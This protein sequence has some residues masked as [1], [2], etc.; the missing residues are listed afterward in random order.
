MHWMCVVCNT[1]FVVSTKCLTH[2][3]NY[4]W[5][6]VGALGMFGADIVVQ[7]TCLMPLRLADQENNIWVSLGSINRPCGQLWLSSWHLIHTFC[8]LRNT[9]HSLAYLDRHLGEIGE[10]LM[11]GI[12][13]LSIGGSWETWACYTFITL[14]DCRHLADKKPS[15]L[16]VAGSD[17][18]IVRSLVL[19]PHAENCNE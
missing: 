18:V 5:V 12:Y 14:G 8:E 15:S 4:S 11:H 10:L 1:I 16:I 6:I 9:S 19:I 17:Q 13:F 7:Q 3:N 2:N